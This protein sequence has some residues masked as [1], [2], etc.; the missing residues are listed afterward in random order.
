MKELLNKPR[1]I[2]AYKQRIQD[3]VEAISVNML[4]ENIQNFQFRDCDIATKVIWQTL[5][6]ENGFFFC[7]EHQKRNSY[8]LYLCFLKYK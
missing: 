5:C 3:V 4:R 7:I 6:K 8:T 2:K 1:T